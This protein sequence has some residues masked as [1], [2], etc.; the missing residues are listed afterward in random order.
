MKKE[1]IQRMIEDKIENYHEES[2]IARA[3]RIAFFTI[4][5]S[6]LMIGYLAGIT[7]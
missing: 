3:R 1:E 5:L 7:A 2:I 4:I 6:M